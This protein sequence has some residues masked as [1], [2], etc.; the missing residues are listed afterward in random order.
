ME[1]DI[2][3]IVCGVKCDHKWDGPVVTFKNGAT[4]S[5]SKCGALAVD[6]SLLEEE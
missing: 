6:V 2:T 1:D 5:C 3:V 4:V